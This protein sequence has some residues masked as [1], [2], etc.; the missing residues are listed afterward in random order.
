M[1]QFETKTISEATAAEL[2][3]YAVTFLGI[4]VAD[5]EDDAKV[6]AKVK[7]ANEGNTIFVAKAAEPSDQT[8]S[9]PPKPADDNI[10]TG[11]GLVG[12]LGRDD[13]K[14]QLT[15][16]AEER[17]GVVVNR[18]KEVGVNGVVWLLKRGESITI[19]YR[20]FKALDDA[21]RHVI[22]HTGA[23]EVRE[24]KVKNTPFNIERFPSDA[25]IR[26]WHE[27]TDAV[28]VP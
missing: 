22:T 2:R 9:P 12:S 5:D 14:V 21:E 18:H 26:A 28:F 8:G 11:A 3:A 24:Q 1:R 6:L 7:A 27:R 10:G 19:P 16:H 20:V 13:P 23:G 17:D 4:P 15:L 25:D